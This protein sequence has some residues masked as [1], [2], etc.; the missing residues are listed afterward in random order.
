MCKTIYLYYCS[1]C[2]HTVTPSIECPK[3]LSIAPPT[4]LFMHHNPVWFSALFYLKYM[5]FVSISLLYN[6]EDITRKA[7]FSTFTTIGMDIRLMSVFSL[8]SQIIFSAFPHVA[9]FFSTWI[10]AKVKFT[11]LLEHPPLNRCMS[12]LKTK[13]LK[14]KNT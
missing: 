4:P 1:L 5:F 10:F 12:S 8:L 3:I 2:R 13:D 7:P 11:P 9:I 6:S 14:Y